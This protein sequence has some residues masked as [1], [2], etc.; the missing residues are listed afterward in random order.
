MVH[1][2]L[3]LIYS[4]GVVVYYYPIVESYVFFLHRECAVRV[5]L[6]RKVCVY[7]TDRSD[8]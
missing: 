2:L 1:L 3:F 7:I 4:N 5:F 6:F 8:L